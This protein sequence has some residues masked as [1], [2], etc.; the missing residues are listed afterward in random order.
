MG[1][2]VRI[3]SETG[4]IS[5][6]FLILISAI[7]IPL[8]RD[9]TEWSQT[10]AWDSLTT[11]R[12]VYGDPCPYPTRIQAFQT[13]GELV[14]RVHA[15]GPYSTE[16]AALDQLGTDYI[17]ILLDPLGS[18]GETYYWFGADPSGN[19]QD[20]R[21]QGGVWD[22]MW[23]A[24]WDVD[25]TTE[26]HGFTLTFHIPFHNFLYQ[27]GAWG[28]NV[29][30]MIGRKQTECALIPTPQQRPRPFFLPIR[31]KL[32]P[33]VGW[34]LKPHGLLYAD[35]SHMQLGRIGVDG[36]V[37]LDLHAFYLTFFPDYGVADV[38]PVYVTFQR[39]AVYI[40]ERRLFFTQDVE[41]FR[42]PI[43]PGLPLMDFFYTR[44][45][46]DTSAFQAGFS[47][48]TGTRV[49]LLGGAKA[50][51]NSGSYHLGALWARTALPEDFIYAALKYT[52][53]IFS[54]GMMGGFYQRDTLTEWQTL[55]YTTGQYAHLTWTVLGGM[56]DS[57]RL[58]GGALQYTSPDIAAYVR[59]MWS[60]HP[61]VASHLAYFPFQ[62]I[63]FVDAGLGKNFYHTGGLA[64][65]SLALGGSY[66]DE[67]TL[68]PSV[69]GYLDGYFFTREGHL[70]SVSIKD[71]KESALQY[72]WVSGQL[73]DTLYRFW[74]VQTRSQWNLSPHLLTLQAEYQSL[75]MNY[76]T[77]NL[78]SKSSV[79]ADWNVLLMKPLRF[80]V[81]VAYHQYSGEFPVWS[82]GSRI[83][84]SPLSG[85]QLQLG[86]THAFSSDP[87]LSSIY[88]GGTQYYYLSSRWG[89]FW[90]NLLLE[91]D[92]DGRFSPTDWRIRLKLRWDLYAGG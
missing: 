72:D 22:P 1:E 16:H 90:I 53:P 65:V 49:P 81:S 51:I 88:S 5:M 57:S 59:T 69:Y 35:Q 8:S 37:K 68:S 12:P 11:Q 56:S 17:A 45:I 20:Q 6:V 26:P 33:Y 74:S 24:R 70:I 28:F 73:S 85:H 58:G 13:P 61:W 89:S 46:G 42:T 25:V 39:Y 77:F 27:R 78:G 83:R 23:D 71:G 31:L 29:V 32:Q 87:M 19:K 36:S 75:S 52:H 15:D 43:I 80:H 60:M 84:W 63:R 14:V 9:S 21:I 82:L 47:T 86:V 40:P 54:A 62:D 4:G 34:R 38:D 76:R 10:V 2:A 50:L 3:F 18:N 7:S 66:W 91:R 67:S 30:R 48:R 92:H 55:L 44:H 41:P 79:T 64:T